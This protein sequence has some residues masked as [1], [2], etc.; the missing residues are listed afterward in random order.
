MWD[1]VKKLLA[2]KDNS[3]DGDELL[4]REHALATPEH[5][6]KKLKAIDDAVEAG[7]PV[8]A[9]EQL[10]ALLCEYPSRT[11]VLQR[12]VVVLDRVGE[13]RLAGLFEESIT[14]IDSESMAQLA[15]AFCELNDTSIAMA[16]AGAAR[17]LGGA[18]DAKAARALAR[19]LSR[20]GHHHDVV[21]V[22]ERFEGRWASED[23]LQCYAA[24]TILVGDSK[25]WNRIAGAVSQTQDGASLV[26]AAARVGAFGHDANEDA[27]RHVHFLQYGAVL[28]HGKSILD[29][30][31]F[32]PGQVGHLLTQV[33]T[34]LKAAG[35]NLDR[36]ASATP[37]GEVLARWLGAL[38]DIPSMPLNSR[39][40]EQRVALIVADDED[41]LE[42]IRR[43]ARMESP[44]VLI[45]LVR[46]P[47][48]TITPVAD[49]LGAL[50]EGVQLPL[51]AV[52][53]AAA[54]RTPPSILVKKL[55]DASEHERMA[56][57]S[58]VLHEWVKKHA[59]WLSLIDPPALSSRLEYRANIPAWVREQKDERDSV[60][61]DDTE[62]VSAEESSSVEEAPS[63]V[64]ETQDD[65]EPGQ[66]L[67]LESALDQEPTD[68]S[69]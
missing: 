19:I 8:E 6:G 25:R 37:R 33:A 62:A 20:E 36:I 65:V 39:L 34:I 46:D 47:G 56:V 9:L 29:G 23:M 51:D 54:E 30:R 55:M 48:C 4:E 18:D 31:V 5:L 40:V 28:A 53:G 52:L 63:E 2:S 68:R 24:S 44:V 41:L 42:A 15:E 35:S 21:E 57:P 66:V 17:Q 45:Q 59:R 64:E 11:D 16:F 22:M 14:H 61:S 60:V 43:D 50:G 7:E 38:L 3:L 32:T 49:V 69:E 58:S 27:L 12:A 1:R 13:S 67:E 10:R 26:R